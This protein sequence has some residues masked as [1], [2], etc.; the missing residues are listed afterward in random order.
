M[1]LRN[2]FWITVLALSLV[3]FGQFAIDIYLPSFASMEKQLNTSASMIQLTLTFY[4]ISY[5]FTQLI[6]GPLSDRFGRRKV[7]LCGMIIFIAGSLGTYIAPTI[8]WVLATRFIQGA[9]ISSANVLCRAILRDLYPGPELEKKTPY[10]GMVWVIPPIV[11]PVLGGY[12]EDFFGWRTNFL[13]LAGIV[14]IEFLLIYFFL[15]E[16]KD[17]SEIHSIHPKTIW[18][19]YKTLLSNQAFL[20]YVT[21]DMILF[22]AFSC[23]YAV[24]PFLLQVRLDLSAISLGWMLLLISSGYM[25]GSYLNIFL[26]HRLSQK[27]IMS[28]GV[29]CICLVAFAMLTVALMGIMTVFAIVAL[30]L[31]FFFGIGLIFTNCIAGCLK[32]FPPLA[33]S[34]SALWGLF[35]FIGGTIGSS[36]MTLFSEKNQVPLVSVFTVQSILVGI[37]LYSLVFR[38]NRQV[39]K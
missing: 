26:T 29:L 32:I 22:G 23:F 38:A 14:C 34:A 15:P 17:P 20:G 37:V 28:I 19:N 4:L 27:N 31:L 8:A 25:M 11:A 39:Q 33:G 35:A 16:T 21:T 3:T 24:G 30:Q 2:K 9:G 18:K 12:I 10:L 6:Y 13:F 7:L 5:G 36:L 1:R